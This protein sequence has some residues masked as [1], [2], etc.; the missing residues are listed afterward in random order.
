MKEYKSELIEEIGLNTSH[1]L[2]K[3]LNALVKHGWQYKNHVFM[4]SYEKV[5]HKPHR[6]YLFCLLLEKEVE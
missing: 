3:R 1:N 5:Q 6:V 4:E 2:D